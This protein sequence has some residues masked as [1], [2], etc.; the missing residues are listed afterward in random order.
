MRLQARPTSTTAPPGVPLKPQLHP[1]PG[2]LLHVWEEK[3]LPLVT[4]LQKLR[5]LQLERQ[6]PKNHVRGLLHVALPQLWQTRS[7]R[8][9]Q[10][11]AND[12]P[13][14]GHHVKGPGLAVGPRQLPLA[15]E[16]GSL[17]HPKRQQRAL[18]YSAATV[19]KATDTATA[20]ASTRSTPPFP[21]TPCPLAPVTP[22]AGPIPYRYEP[23]RVPAEAVHPLG[24]APP[25][26]RSHG[27]RV[28][29]DSRRIPAHSSSR[30]EPTCKYV[31]LG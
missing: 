22:V 23:K 4:Q 29:F 5:P 18:L 26:P 11:G 17:K 21:P 24:G 16:Q 15:H 27:V 13:L 20:T 14:R 30:V 19:A 6:S 8:V 1:R 12:P 3:P 10:R 25:A 7:E 31:R 2:P 28:S 9:L